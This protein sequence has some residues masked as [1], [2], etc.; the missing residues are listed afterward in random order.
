[1]NM[2]GEVVILYEMY[3]LYRQIFTDGRDFPK[4]FPAAGPQVEILVGPCYY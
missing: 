1:M 4:E 3:Y 2:P